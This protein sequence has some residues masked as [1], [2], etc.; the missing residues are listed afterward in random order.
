M[1]KKKSRYKFVDSDDESE[2]AES[3]FKKKFEKAYKSRDLEHPLFD[4]SKTEAKRLVTTTRG[5]RELKQ[6]DP[7]LFRALAKWLDVST[8]E[9]KSKVDRWITRLKIKTGDTKTVYRNLTHVYTT[10]AKSGSVNRPL[11]LIHMDL[12]DVGRLN[13]DNR[14]YRYPFILVAVDGFS[15]YTVLVPVKSKSAKHVLN[16]SK[17]AF[18]QFGLKSSCKPVKRT[19]RSGKKETQADSCLRKCM[20]TTRVQ[21]NRGTEFIN[22]DLKKFLRRRGY[23]LFSS[24]GSGKAYLAKSKIGQMKRQLVR[25]QNILEDSSRKH[26][27]RK[28]KIRKSI[29]AIEK[30]KEKEEIRFEC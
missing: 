18:S 27:K 6:Y 26:L 28:T 30:E 24:R 25:V 11:A 16:A 3:S 9:L 29:V 13:P 19:L 5:R 21:T 22:K 10:L 23:D 12:A 8:S 2:R 7:A 15:N 20:T 4:A 1:S 14:R 17:N